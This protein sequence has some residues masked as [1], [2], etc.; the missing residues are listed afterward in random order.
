[1]GHGNGIKPLFYHI[2]ACGSQVVLNVLND[3]Y[4]GDIYNILLLLLF[5]KT[6][7]NCI[8]K[9][10]V[11]HLKKIFLVGSYRFGIGTD[12]TYFY[13]AEYVYSHIEISI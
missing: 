13:V 5:L 11:Y 1:M 7:F 8:W 3:R 2:W 10:P 6:S 12:N 9:N 4:S